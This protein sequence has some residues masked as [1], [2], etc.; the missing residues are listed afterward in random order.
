MNGQIID[1]HSHMVPARLA[2]NATAGG[3]HYG[4]EFGRDERGKITSSVGGKPPFSLPWPTPLETPSERVTSMD[5]IGVDVHMLSLSPSL[6]W[7]TT[8]AKDAV[9]MASEV[10]DDIADVVREFPTRY[11]GL[12]HLP[13]QDPSASVDELERCVRDHGF[14]G[15]I[16][17]THVD[18]TNWDSPDLFPV[19]QAAQD[20]GVLLFVHP[21]RGRAQSF[22]PDYHLKNL[23]GNPLETTI[24][25]A[26]LI[27]GGVLDRL[28]DLKLCFAHGGGYGCL[29]IA[30]MDH[31]HSIRAEAQGIAQMPSE[32][33][34]GL[35][36][37][38]LVHGHRTLDQ[39]IDLAGISQVV[40]GS[41]YPADMGEPRPVDFIRSHPTLTDEE[42][43]KILSENL[44]SL[45]A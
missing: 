21:T 1:V 23:V 2:Q 8:P 38:S 27:F 9:L 17:G 22:L 19:L 16:I 10:N 42:R 24:S 20:L 28:P 32:Y 5:N 31:G 30:R 4:I 13:L 6:I 37:D 11:R 7:Y 34:K 45:L 3:L 29:G 40:L 35:Y 44:T 41:D 36:F 39:V 15:A 26:S 14:D 25:L 43:W 18:G 12:A 33:L